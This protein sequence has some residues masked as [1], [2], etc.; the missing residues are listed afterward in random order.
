[1]TLLV[2]RPSWVGVVLWRSGFLAM[3][4]EQVPPPPNGENLEELRNGASLYQEQTRLISTAVLDIVLGAVTPAA[5]AVEVQ[6]GRSI[7]FQHH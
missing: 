5:A 7:K 6:R 4:K 1:M 2:A 3:D